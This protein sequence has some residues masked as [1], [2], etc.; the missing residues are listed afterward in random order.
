M[1]LIHTSTAAVA[2]K[3]SVRAICLDGGGYLGLATAAFLKEAERHF[4]ARCADTF[5]LFC[6][7]ST[8]G[9]IALALAKGMS[10]DDVVDLYRELGREVFKNPIPFMRAMRF[11]RGLFTSRYRNTRLR[12]ALESAFGATRIG[13]LRE[14]GK[15]VVIPA[16][17]ISEGRPRLFK[18]NHHH[19]LTRDDEYR[20]VDVALATSAAPTFLPVVS[21]K[22][23]TTGAQEK[24]ADGGL[25][26]NNPALIAYTEAL[27][28]LGA[29]RGAVQILSVSTPRA[30]KAESTTPLTWW[31]RVSLHRGVLHWISGL[32][33]TFVDSAMTLSH[34]TLDCLM[35]EAGASE[36]YARFP[37]P[38]QR[39][40]GLDVATSTATHTLITIGSSHAAQIKTREQLARFFAAPDVE[41][42]VHGQ[43]SEAV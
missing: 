1:Q 27:R 22:S 36:N 17:S 7:T 30:V 21:I 20:L 40:L 13:D 37:L 25:V 8:G 41:G 15:Y 10:A 38:M 4:N 5:Q 31:E 16:F 14:R 24:F 11:V 42:E 6:G 35:R 32:A 43:R 2:A 12:A 18:T 28:Y 3:P 26:A 29:P 9:I 19:S 39:G 33:D 34:H 23:P